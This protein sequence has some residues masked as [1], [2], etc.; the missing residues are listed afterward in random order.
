MPHQSENYETFVKCVFERLVGVE[1]HHQ[2]EYIGR[3]SRRKIIVDV[4]FEYD[5]AGAKLL[6]LVE[7]K[8]HARKVSVE[9]VEEFHSKFDDI[10]A[11]KGIVVTT[12]GFQSGAV[13]TAVGRGIALAVLTEEAERE[14]LIY[15][16]NS[17]DAIGPPMDRDGFMRG[18]LFMDEFDDGRGMSFSSMQG[19]LGLL[20]TEAFHKING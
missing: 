10:G 18:A 12:V 6:F 3:V 17:K 13:K 5:V 14:G 20:Y 9:D 16:A 11:H 19:F 15:I 4:S 7:C 2:R 8:H 1:V